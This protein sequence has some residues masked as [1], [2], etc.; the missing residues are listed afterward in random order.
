[1]IITRRAISPTTEK[2]NVRNVGLGMYVHLLDADGNKITC[3]IMLDTEAMTC[4][5]CANKRRPYPHLREPEDSVK[6]TEPVASFY[7]N[8]SAPEDMLA[9][10]RQYGFE[11]RGRP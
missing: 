7:I 4:V 6:T 11:V 5:V 1:M 2:V 9:I 8:D 10:A 3:A